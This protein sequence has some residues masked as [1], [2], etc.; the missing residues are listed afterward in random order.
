MG[1]DWLRHSVFLCDRVYSDLVP[2]LFTFGQHYGTH[3]ELFCLTS[4]FQSI[5][6]LYLEYI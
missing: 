4:A 3:G 5:D 6:E 1:L 2:F